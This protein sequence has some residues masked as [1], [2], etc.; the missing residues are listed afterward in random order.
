MASSRHHH[1]HHHHHHGGGRGP[2]RVAPGAGAHVHWHPRYPPSARAESLWVS[3]HVD[4][5]L[6]VWDALEEFR[7]SWGLLDACSF[8]QFCS[9]V[10]RH[11]LSSGPH[12][13]KG[14]R[15]WPGSAPAVVVA[16]EGGA[17]EE[18]RPSSPPP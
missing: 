16:A 11:S 9:F 4:E 17:S 10:C 12:L 3:E 2:R 1:G 6:D 5:L 7:S 13:C 14:P 18:E 15:S 8:P